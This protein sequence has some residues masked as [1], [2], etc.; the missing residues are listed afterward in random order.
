MEGSVLNGRSA[1]DINQRET[2]EETTIVKRL[3]RFCFDENSHTV[4]KAP[5]MPRNNLHRNNRRIRSKPL[6]I[7]AKAMLIFQSPSFPS[8][9]KYSIVA[10][11][12]HRGYKGAMRAKR[13]FTVKN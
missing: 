6:K 2:L 9:K 12:E 11:F 5:D 4:L 10:E 3:R 8:R 13:N 1:A 7:K